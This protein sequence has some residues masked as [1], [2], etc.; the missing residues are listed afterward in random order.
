MH[1]AND[2]A[3]TYII[4]TKIK[5]PWLIKKVPPKKQT[6]QAHTTSPIPIIPTPYHLKESLYTVT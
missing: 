2:L 5:F 3:Y 6:I 4:P 1:D